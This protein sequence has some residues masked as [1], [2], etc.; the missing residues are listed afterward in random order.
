[1]GGGNKGARE[2]DVLG[3]AEWMIRSI[4]PD[5][6]SDVAGCSVVVSFLNF[7]CWANGSQ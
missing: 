2:Q 3:T 1:M 5:D 4:P 6:V 7:L